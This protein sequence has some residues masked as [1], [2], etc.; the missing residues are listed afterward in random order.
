MMLLGWAA[1]RVLVRK[2]APQSRQPLLAIQKLLC[3]S[4]AGLGRVEHSAAL[5]LLFVA[6][7]Q[8]EYCPGRQAAQDRR[9]KVGYLLM[10]PRTT[11]PWKARQSY[12]R[13]RMRLNHSGRN[14]SYACIF[15]LSVHDELSLG[16]SARHLLTSRLYAARTSPA[17]QG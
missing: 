8:D 17:L 15:L 13:S 12:C 9:Q 7:L 4:F 16:S 5:E 1:V 14:R 6:H 11:G 2:T 10:T 3:H